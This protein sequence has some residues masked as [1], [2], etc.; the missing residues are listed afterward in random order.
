M[1]E[2]RLEFTTIRCVQPFTVIYLSIKLNNSCSIR[3]SRLHDD[4]LDCPPSVSIYLRLGILIYTSK[5]P[6]GTQKLVFR[7][8]KLSKQKQSSKIVL[9]GV[10]NPA[11]NDARVLN[12]TSTLN[13]PNSR[14]LIFKKFH[15]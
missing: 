1:L 9:M 4:I 5:N 10:L 13:V 6:S 11:M 7:I 8:G 3:H 15:K 12:G 14:I 2:Y